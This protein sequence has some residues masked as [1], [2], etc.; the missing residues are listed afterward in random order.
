MPV[1]FAFILYHMPSGLVLYWTV[2]TILSVGE[3]L[4][5]KRMLARLKSSP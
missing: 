3:Q 1:F 2:S 5:I 4:L